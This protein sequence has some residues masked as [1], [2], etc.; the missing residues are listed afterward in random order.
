M[1][2]DELQSLRTGLEALFNFADL[3]AASHKS[4]LREIYHRLVIK[5]VGIKIGDAYLVAAEICNHIFHFA[6]AEISGIRQES[7]RV[8]SAYNCNIFA[9]GHTRYLRVRRS[10]A[11]NAALGCN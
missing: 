5:T 8:K 2:T 3:A 1:L 4:V 11:Y 6:L 7:T 10:R 9:E